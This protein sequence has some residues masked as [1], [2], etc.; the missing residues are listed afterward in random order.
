M[1]AVEQP[2]NPT[3][4]RPLVQGEA[5]A[6]EEQIAG[7]PITPEKVAPAPAPPAPVERRSALTKGTSAEVVPAQE[8]Q[9]I[10]P[11]ARL[12]SREEQIATAI[13][14]AGEVSPIT[15]RLALSLRGIPQAGVMPE[16][17]PLSYRP[18]PAVEMPEENLEPEVEAE[19]EV[20]PLP[21]EEAP[22]VSAAAVEET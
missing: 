3:N 9:F 10:A 14:G 16:V 8:M 15:R 2:T 20:P 17:L 22:P 18:T 7:A 13:L 6:I 4:P 11:V 1:G 21:L 5:G 12:S 19:E